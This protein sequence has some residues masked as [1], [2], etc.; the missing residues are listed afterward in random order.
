MVGN[1]RPASGAE[2]HIAH[3]L[4][5]KAIRDEIPHH[6]HGV[7]VALGTVLIS[8]LYYMIFSQDFSVFL[9]HIMEHEFVR[10]NLQE[11]NSLESRAREGLLR[12]GYGEQGGQMIA[13]WRQNLLPLAEV[14]PLIQRLESIWPALQ[15]LVQKFVPAPEY[16][17]RIIHNAR[18]PLSMDYLKYTPELLYQTL[19]CAKEVRNRFTVLVLVDQL[20]LLETFSQ[21]IANDYFF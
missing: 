11:I 14:E 12:L 13:T 9:Q 20:G 2:H 1:S 18:I 16:L 21:R 10:S 5:L 6:F 17:N 15:D 4:E 8:T 3:F 19:V 7:N